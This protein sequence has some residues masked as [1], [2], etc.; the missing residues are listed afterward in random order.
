M[1]ESG[2]FDNNKNPICQGQHFLFTIPDDILKNERSTF[3]GS[4]L[5]QHMKKLSAKYYLIYVIPTEFLVINLVTCFL[6]DDLTPFTIADEEVLL[7][8]DAK[9]FAYDGIDLAT[10]DKSLPAIAFAQDTF[11]FVRYLTAKEGLILEPSP[12]VDL[13]QFQEPS[14]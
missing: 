14:K 12:S 9:S 4:H 5:G 1:I 8:R 13:S 6:K 7:T 11:T 10:V 3:Y 2:L